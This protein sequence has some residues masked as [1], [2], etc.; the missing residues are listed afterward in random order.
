MSVERHSSLCYLEQDPNYYHNKDCNTVM[1][2]DRKRINDTLVYRA[3]LVYTE[4]K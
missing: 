2:R 4:A 1:R 3:V